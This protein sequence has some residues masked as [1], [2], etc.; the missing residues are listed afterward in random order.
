MADLRNMTPSR[1]TRT[2]LGVAG[3]LAASAAL[4]VPAQAASLVT[5]TDCPTPALTQPFAAWGD[6]NRYKLIDGAAFDGEA[7]GWKLTGGAAVRDG[8]LS[9]PAGSTATSAPVCVGHAEPT[10]RFF[11]AGTGLAPVLTVSVQVQL[12]TGT[13]LTLPI[14]V[15]TGPAWK[16]SPIML[17]LANYLPAAGEYTNVRFV[18]APLLS[19]WQIDDVFVDPF[20]RG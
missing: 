6:E 7:A 17:V 3:A 11:G 20:N 14:G 5:P 19:H 4:A 16:P 10:L 8:R 18:F 15:D 9:L 13:W 12:L 2:A 1:L